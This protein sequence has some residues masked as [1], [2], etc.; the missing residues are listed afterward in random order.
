ME[1]TSTNLEILSAE[2]ILAT[3]YPYKEFLIG[4]NLWPRGGKMLLTAENGTGKSAV[5]LY[6]AACLASGRPLFGF[7]NKHKGNSSFGQPT[8]PV[9]GRNRVLYVDCEI[10]H[11]IRKTLRLEPLVNSFGA[12][13][14][15]L[16]NFVK[17]PSIY[18]LEHEGLTRLLEV[19]KRHKPDAVIFDPFSSLHTQDEN[20]SKVRTPL[21][22]A[23]RI[24]DETGAAV[25]IVHHT[26][27]KKSRNA[28]GDVIEKTGK[29]QSRGHTAITDW[30]DLNLLLTDR[31]PKHRSKVLEL[32]FAKTRYNKAPSKRLIVADI[33]KMI[34]RPYDKEEDDEDYSP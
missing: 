1:N 7:V 21:S 26:S 23:D 9:T 33:G 34:F 28:N 27:A 29:E 15:K 8:F 25:M 24:I 19:V 12:E 5:A 32:S 10:P 16:L 11:R 18:K 3:D 31:T 22:N 4:P 2:E 13:F 30:C 20:S 17:F 14:A 6:I